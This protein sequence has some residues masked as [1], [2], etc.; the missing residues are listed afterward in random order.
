VTHDSGLAVSVGTSFEGFVAGW[1]DALIQF[2]Y[3][4]CGDAHD[5]HDLVQD[6]LVA[7]WLKWDRVSTTDDPLAYVRRTIVNRNISVW[8]RSRR[9]VVVAEIDPG[10]VTP[11]GAV[12]DRD[13]ALRLLGTLPRRQRAAV[14]LKV[15]EGYDYADVAVILGVTE[16]NARQ[17]TSRGL[18]ALRS[19]LAGRTDRTRRRATGQGRKDLVVDHIQ[20]ERT[21]HA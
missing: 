10:V 3:L 16:A 8:R 6:A 18:A 9:S 21:E 5:A 1:G 20:R 17:L 2:A 12:D 19:R 7:V 13:W 15:L 14:V 4:M 11:T